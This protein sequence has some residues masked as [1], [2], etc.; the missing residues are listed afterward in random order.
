MAEKEGKLDFEK[1]M[2]NLEKVVEALESGDLTLEK[3][4]QA[5]EEGV[6]L[7]KTCQSKLTET[8]KKIEVLTK[9]LDG[10]LK[11]EPFDPDQVPRSSVK[12]RKKG[13]SSGVDDETVAGEES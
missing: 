7:V 13:G 11:K 4:L 8:E 10:S 6:F 3:A 1:A 12:G 2:A 9:A 5:Y